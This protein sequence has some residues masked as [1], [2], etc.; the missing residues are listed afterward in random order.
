VKEA[1]KM[2]SKIGFA[3][4]VVGLTMVGSAI[5]PSAGAAPPDDACLFVTQAQVRA[6]VGMAMGA[7]SHV[8]PTFLK[9]CTW[10]PATATEEVKAVTLNLQSADGYDGAKRLMEQTEAMMKA[11]GGEGAASMTNTS[12]SGIGD[13]AYY[14]SVGSNITSL[15]FKKGKFAFKIAIYGSLPMEKRNAA[16][17]TLALQVLS[18][19]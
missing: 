9:T 6:A 1:Y 4:I 7:G 2:F 16:E 14:S 15:I 12:A 13:D 18:K 3:A 8:T 19:L 11:K 5:A 10:T 17:K